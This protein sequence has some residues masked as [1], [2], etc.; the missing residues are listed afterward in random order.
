MLNNRDKVRAAIEAARNEVPPPTLKQIGRRLGYTCEAVIVPTFAEMCAS[1]KEWRRAWFKDQRHSL[2]L[3]IRSWVVTEATPTVTS[4]LPSLRDLSNIFSIE[5]PG[6]QQ[7]TGP[8]FG[9]TCTKSSHRSSA[10][11]ARGGLPDHLRPA[12]KRALSVSAARKM[13]APPRFNAVFPTHSQRHRRGESD[14][15]PYNAPAE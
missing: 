14:L 13:C 7:G 9:R 6:R 8:P 11:L 12:T 2:R 15:R 1:Y 3:A 5:F 4:V 10:C